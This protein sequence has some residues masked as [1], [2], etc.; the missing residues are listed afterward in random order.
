MTILVVILLL[1][2]IFFLTVGSLGIIRLPDFYSRIH[3]VGKAETLGT[4]LVLGG[5]AA[6]NGFEI[7]SFKLL[8]ILVFIALANPTAT[9]AIAREAIRSGLQPWVRMKENGKSEPIKIIETIH[10]NELDN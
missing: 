1:A 9:H 8:V 4:M 5:L 7:N 6:Y 2:G 10:D 3:A